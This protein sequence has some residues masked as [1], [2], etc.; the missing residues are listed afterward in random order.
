LIERAPFSP[1]E[2][3]L[4]RSVFSE[5]ARHH[6]SFGQG[7]FGLRGAA[8]GSVSSSEEFTSGDS[9][10]WLYPPSSFQQ[11][12]K[13]GTL[14]LPAIAAQP[15]V[16]GGTTP[17]TTNAASTMPW[18]VPAGFN[19]FL[20]TLAIEFVANGGAAWTPGVLVGGVPP[21]QFLVR[22]DGHPA[23]DYG[24]ICYSPGAINSPTPFAG[25]PIK[26][27]SLVEVLVL[28]NSIVVTTQFVEARLQGYYYPR[29]LEPKDMW[30]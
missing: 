12:D 7:G 15:A 29:S 19:G 6:S 27:G 26:E 18:K 4:W 10:P 20:K 14:A 25:V 30:Q 1:A 23:T 2:F 8:G 13:Y 28:N 24:N 21:L 3:R 16:I 17:T 22:I 9:Y 5:R 11:L